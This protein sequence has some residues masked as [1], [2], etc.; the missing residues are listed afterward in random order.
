[1]NNFWN[2]QIFGVIIGGGFT[3]LGLVIS[4][5]FETKRFNKYSQF[6]LR[7]DIWKSQHDQLNRLKGL[8]GYCAYRLKGKRDIL[9][10]KE[11]LYSRLNEIESLYGYYTDYWALQ[12]SINSLVSMARLI[13]VAAEN[14]D[15][16][17]LSEQTHFD[18]IAQYA[19][20]ALDHCNE[21]IQ[22]GKLPKIVS[23]YPPRK[24]LF[25]R[26]W[27]KLIWRQ[28]KEKSK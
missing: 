1:M 4:N 21:I 25:K 6:E 14:N 15:L 11:E 27:N 22:S 3:L 16:E 10:Y 5:L 9:G 20:D 24:P 12:R 8:V 23:L 7:K 28:K 18:A 17:I 26:I 13:I 2:S 19:S